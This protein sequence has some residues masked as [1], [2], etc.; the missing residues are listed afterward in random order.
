MTLARACVCC[1]SFECVR[2]MTRMFVQFSRASTAEYLLK[3]LSVGV[4]IV[5]HPNIS[6]NQASVIYVTTN[7]AVTIY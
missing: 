6:P 7:I 3:M 5:T 1:A 2:M 4:L